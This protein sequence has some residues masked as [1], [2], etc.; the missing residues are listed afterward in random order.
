[1]G[2]LGAAESLKRTRA[3]VSTDTKSAAIC[4]KDGDYPVLTTPKDATEDRRFCLWLSVRYDHIV[5]K[6][7]YSRYHHI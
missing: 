5:T 2:S 7:W 1:M 6:V 4:A 3:L